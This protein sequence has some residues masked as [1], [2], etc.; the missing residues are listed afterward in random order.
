VAYCLK[1]GH[2]ICQNFLS[3]WMAQFAHGS[4]L[5]LSDALSRQAEE[6]TNF[7][8]SVQVA[9]FQPIAELEDFLLSGAELLQHFFQLGRQQVQ[10]HLRFGSGAVGGLDKL[11]QLRIFL[12]ADRSMQ[13][14]SLATGFQ[15]G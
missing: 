13:R 7:G 6:L 5:N 12:F 4:C 3:A 8:E 11:H 10:V 9:I 14:K 2:P 15:E 1:R